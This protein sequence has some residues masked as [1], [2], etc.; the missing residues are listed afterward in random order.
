MY[1]ELGNVAYGRG[2]W[3]EAADWYARALA[4]LEELGNRSGWR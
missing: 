1:H 2:R 3:D 4:I